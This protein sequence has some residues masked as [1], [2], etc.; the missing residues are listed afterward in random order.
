LDKIDDR[1]D[2]KAFKK[3]GKSKKI[4]RSG[5]LATHTAERIRRF[6]IWIA[7]AL[8]TFF[9]NGWIYSIVTLTTLSLKHSIDCD[10]IDGACKCLHCYTLLQRDVV[11]KLNVFSIILTIVFERDQVSFFLG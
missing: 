5:N 9:T 7:Y 2:A 4:S 10:Y 8:R 6:R 11:T 3:S 1:K